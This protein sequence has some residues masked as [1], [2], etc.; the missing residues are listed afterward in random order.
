MTLLANQNVDDFRNP[1][2]NELKITSFKHL[3]FNSF[4]IYIFM[5]KYT[6]QTQYKIAFNNSMDAS[7][8]SISSLERLELRGPR[9]TSLSVHYRQQPTQLGC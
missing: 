2:K 3:N 9:A 8:A 7:D 6:I 1:M 5:T 4:S